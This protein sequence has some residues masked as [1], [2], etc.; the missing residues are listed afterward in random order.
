M[1]R[2]W[3][4]SPP[5]EEENDDDAGADG[6]ANLP[7]ADG[8]ANDDPV[9]AELQHP[10]WIGR[11]NAQFPQFFRITDQ[12][13]AQRRALSYER[14]GIP[15]DWRRAFKY[16]HNAGRKGS[17]V[18]DKERAW[19]KACRHYLSHVWSTSGLPN[20]G[21]RFAYA[22]APYLDDN[23]AEKWDFLNGNPPEGWTGPAHRAP[24]RPPPPRQN[25]PPNAAPRHPLLPNAAVR[26]KEP[27]VASMVVVP[28]PP[29]VSPGRGR[30]RGSIFDL[31]N[32]GGA[33]RDV[34]P[35]D[36][37]IFAPG[38]GRGAAPAIGHGAGRG[39]APGAP[40]VS[41]SLIPRGAARGDVQPSTSRPRPITPPVGWPRATSS[42]K[43]STSSSSSRFPC[44]DVR[45]QDNPDLPTF[46][47]RAG[48]P[49]AGK[50]K[51]KKRRPDSTTQS[52][53]SEFAGKIRKLHQDLDGRQRELNED[54]RHVLLLNNSMRELPNCSPLS[55]LQRN[56][57]NPSQFFSAETQ[58]DTIT[59]PC[60]CMLCPTH[61]ALPRVA[62]VAATSEADTVAVGTVP[63]PP[64]EENDDDELMDA[65]NAM[66]IK[67]M[68]PNNNDNNDD[69]DDDRAA[70]RGEADGNGDNFEDCRDEF[71]FGDDEDDY[72]DMK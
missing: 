17:Y 13:E 54:R 21:K 27:R 68:D 16:T 72:V 18:N 55:R 67:Q 14:D 61:R 53:E 29:P 33:G 5:R 10:D 44:M 25:A 48:N 26:P 8:P 2:N 31:I 3:G 15:E 46:V 70:N 71:E 30:G 39:V 28:S 7:G 49:S 50:G 57:T 51:S 37:R 9:D 32:P 60:G 52:F 56:E 35:T 19:A 34:A 23:C 47:S 38:A 59:A 12:A 69:D 58:T 42:P 36:R 45:K 40:P 62:G 20:G 41:D 65:V 63:P 66:A 4:D 64:A 22:R 11:R 1:P 24:S 43:P 6:P